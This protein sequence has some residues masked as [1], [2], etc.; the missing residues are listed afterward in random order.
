M[1]DESSAKFS[2][3][4]RFGTWTL[5][6]WGPTARGDEKIVQVQWQNAADGWIAQPLDIYVSDGP[7][8]LR[9]LAD[10]VAAVRLN[11]ADR[12]PSTLPEK[13]PVSE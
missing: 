11:S 12:D 2:W 13:L 9:S 8:C 5:C 4:W 7:E 3:R 6:A 1:T 10:F